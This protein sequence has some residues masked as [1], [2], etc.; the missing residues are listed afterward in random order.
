[1]LGAKPDKSIESMFD[2]LLKKV[3][4]MKQQLEAGG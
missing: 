3:E 2:D 4:N 1:M